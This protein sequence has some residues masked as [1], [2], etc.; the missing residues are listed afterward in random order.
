MR[1]HMVLI[2]CTLALAAVA[3]GCGG[4]RV[5]EGNPES[6]AKAYFAYLRDTKVDKARELA[7]FE[8]DA[9]KEVWEEQVDD[10][11][12]RRRKGARQWYGDPFKVAEIPGPEG[13]W[14]AVEVQWR[15]RTDLGWMMGEHYTYLMRTVDDKWRMVIDQARLDQGVPYHP[16]DL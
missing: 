13:K 8:S 2:V 16:K 5:D 11:V 4:G 6:V 3:A 1:R 7:T 12:Q 14:A 9:V 15:F 10:Y